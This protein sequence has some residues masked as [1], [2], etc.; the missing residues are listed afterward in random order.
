MYQINKLLEQEQEQFLST[1]QHIVN[2]HKLEFQ[3]LLNTEI[4][5][6]II[7]FKSYLEQEIRN[8]I[9]SSLSTH[10]QNNLS[11]SQIISDLLLVLQKYFNR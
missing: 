3:E 11:S 10:I 8:S 5:N 2:E 6:M 4:S 7:K 1:I 9:S